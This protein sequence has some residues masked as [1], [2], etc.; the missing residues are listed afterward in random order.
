MVWR[1]FGRFSCYPKTRKTIAHLLQASNQATTPLQIFSPLLLSATLASSLDCSD[2]LS[3]SPPPTP[4]PSVH[5]QLATRT[6]QGV[7]WTTTL[8]SDPENVVCC[9]YPGTGEYDKFFEE[10]IYTCAGC[11]TPLYRSTTKFNL[12]CGWPAFFEGL[13]GAI[14]RT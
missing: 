4:L 8:V 3:S 13:L 9:R 2:L 12:G 7:M 1:C 6:L 14:N 10:G 11:G 5:S